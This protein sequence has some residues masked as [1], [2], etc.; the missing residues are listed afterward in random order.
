[1]ERTTAVNELLGALDG[2]VRMS[3]RRRIDKMEREYDY[4]R[5]REEHDLSFALS[6][7]WSDQKFYVLFVLNSI[8]QLCVGPL[9]AS[10]RS[11]GGIGRNIA[12]RHGSDSY[13]SGRARV[14]NAMAID[15][16]NLASKL[17]IEPGLLQ[18]NTCKDLVYW[19]A[20]GERERDGFNGH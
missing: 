8:Y 13:D 6:C 11:S 14:V 3:I 18:K 7:G 9:H 2:P 20:R 15:F 17:G 5:S 12:I 1:M 19:I 4:L 16:D 10:A